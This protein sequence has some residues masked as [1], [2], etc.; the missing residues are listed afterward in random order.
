VKKLRI[1]YNAPVVLTFA[2]IA[3]IVQF[4]PE[5]VRGEWFVSYPSFKYGTR[6]YV[7]LVTHIFGHASWEHLL[8]NFMLI[9][10]IG[11]ILEERHG[12]LSLL[13]M[14]L[15]T[16]VVEGFADTLVSEPTLGASGIAFMMII[17]AST[18]NIKAGDIPLTFIA[19]AIMYLGRE[20]VDM[21]SANDHVSHFTHVMGGLAGAA[22]G[23]FGAAAPRAS[24]AAKP[25]VTTQKSLG[26]AAPSGPPRTR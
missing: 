6:A 21:A 7:G 2:L 13:F 24:K 26:T 11:P 9:L 18:A 22:F 23:F 25:V 3:V 1:T 12:S 16:A 10:L 17:L 19:V 15:V 14:I 8:A 20:I 4:L 5:A